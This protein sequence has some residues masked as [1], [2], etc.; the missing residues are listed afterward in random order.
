MAT[1]MAIRIQDGLSFIRP[2][3]P[4]VERPAGRSLRL[5]GRRSTPPDRSRSLPPTHLQGK[6]TQSNSISTFTRIGLLA[7]PS[8]SAHRCASRPKGK[9]A[10]EIDGSLLRKGVGI[11]PPAEATPG[12]PGKIIEDRTPVKMIAFSSRGGSRRGLRYTLFNDG[13]DRLRH[14]NYYAL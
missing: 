8:L 6:R 11:P 2:H 10:P 3:L 1:V 14:S 7:E 13:N 5:A 12:R 4:C 9:R